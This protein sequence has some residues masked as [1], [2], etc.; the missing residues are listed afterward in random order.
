MTQTDFDQFRIGPIFRIYASTPTKST[1]ARNHIGTPANTLST[2]YDNIDA[3]MYSNES[4]LVVDVFNES[5]TATEAHKG[6]KK[7]HCW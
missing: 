5:T 1:P 3:K 6:T 2:A 7:N 4:P